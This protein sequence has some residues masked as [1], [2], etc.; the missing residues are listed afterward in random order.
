MA[1]TTTAIEVRRD[2]LRAIVRG[3]YDIQKLRIQMGNR[4]AGNF[5]VKLGQAPGTSE[6]DMDEVGKKLLKQIREAYAKI[7]EGCAKL[8]SVRRFKGSG[9][10]SSYTE[11]VLVAAYIDLETSEAEHFKRIAK[12]IET[13]KLWDAFLKDVKGC[14]AAMAGV[15][16]SEIDISKAKYAS[17]LWKYA[18]L[19]VADDGAGRSRR[20]EHLVEYDYKAKDGTIKKRKG[21]TFNP[22]L[23][24]KLVGVLG[25]CLLKA[26]GAYSTIYRDYKNRLENHTRY[27]TTTKAHR[28]NMAIRYM[29]KMFLVDLYVEWRALEY[30]PVHAPYSE[31]KLGYKHGSA[32]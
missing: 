28:H 4:I 17:S 27:S 16:L 23:K 9:V 2:N 20:Q 30:L 12:V 3:A 22:F 10:I 8:P 14:G 5:K 15:I 18:G 32:T 19:D 11:L 29:I 13:H 25:G 26:N 6:D 24:T 7:T 21:I 1:N 31:A